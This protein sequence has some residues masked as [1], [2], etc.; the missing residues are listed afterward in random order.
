MIGQNGK[1][2]RIW[3][4]CFIDKKGAYRERVYTD[5][6]RL[7][8]CCAKLGVEAEIKDGEKN[9]I[10]RVLRVNE[11]RRKWGWWFELQNECDTKTHFTS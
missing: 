9:V 3:R 2:M 5:P 6:E 10:G 8:K 7:S 11:P 4:I 1:T